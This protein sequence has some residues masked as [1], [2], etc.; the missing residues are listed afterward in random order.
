MS[1]EL[2]SIKNLKIGGSESTESSDMSDDLNDITINPKII[3][4]LKKYLKKHLI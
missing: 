3:Q 2:K 4:I 1:N